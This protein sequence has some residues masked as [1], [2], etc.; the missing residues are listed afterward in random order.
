VLV[1]RREGGE[2]KIYTYDLDKIR[3]GEAEDPTIVN[4]DVIV[5]KRAPARVAVRDSFLGDLI[6]IFNPFNYLSR[7]P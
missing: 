2:K 6:T 3:A 4:D 1:Y 7:P 5:I